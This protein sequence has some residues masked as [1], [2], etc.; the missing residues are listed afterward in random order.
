[1]QILMLLEEVDTGFTFMTIPSPNNN[2][3]VGLELILLLGKGCILYSKV[4]RISV[5][6]VLNVLKKKK[7]PTKKKKNRMINHPNAKKIY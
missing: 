1:M 4:C 6:Y 5:F 3:A 7:K 2:N